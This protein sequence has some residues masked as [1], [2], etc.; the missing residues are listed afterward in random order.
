M[1]VITSISQTLKLLKHKGKKMKQY[2]EFT[3]IANYDPY[4]LKYIAKCSLHS[5]NED[6]KIDVPAL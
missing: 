1:N 4:S 3:D 2:K 6:K 5:L